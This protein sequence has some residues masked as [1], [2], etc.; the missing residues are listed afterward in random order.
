MQLLLILLIRLVESKVDRL[1]IDEILENA[2]RRMSR[3]GVRQRI[4][5]QTPL[6]SMRY[7]P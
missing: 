3:G 6:D 2:A 1:T 4:S 7:S 5:S